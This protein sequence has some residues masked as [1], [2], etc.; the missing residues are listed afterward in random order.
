[1]A[2]EGGMAGDRRLAVA[3]VLREAALGVD[4]DVRRRI[5]RI[6]DLRHARGPGAVAGRDRALRPAA[7]VVLRRHPLRLV[8]RARLG[9]ARARCGDA[10]RR[11]R[12]LDVQARE[13]LVRVRRAV[14][15]ELELLV[16]RERL[17]DV[18]PAMHRARLAPVRAAA[19]RAGLAAW[20][21]VRAVG[22]EDVGEE[23]DVERA[24]AGLQVDGAR[25]AV[26]ALCLEVVDDADRAGGGD[27][28]QRRAERR[29]VERSLARHPVYV[30]DRIGGLVAVLQA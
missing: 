8:L 18:R 21:H 30:A 13:E 29:A 20:A 22:D 15:R 19:A 27:P 16:G 1:P 9:A 6:R 28:R 17:L 25:E 3:A 4:A 7:G 11:R 10:A 26:V 24:L 2:R 23:L 14:A 5:D 12:E